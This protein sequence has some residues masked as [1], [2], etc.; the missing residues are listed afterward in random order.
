LPFVSPRTAAASMPAEDPPAITAVP[1]RFRLHRWLPLVAVVAVA[2]VVAATGWHR[3][4]SL[5]NL[6]RYRTA[7]DGF[8]ATH[9][10][11]AILT[12][13][14]VYVIVAALS[15]PGGALVLTISGG[16]LFGTLVG[17]LASL[18]GATIGGTIIFLV[19]RTAFGE[20]LF[21]RAGP[22]AA[23]LAEGF[24]ENAFNYLLF[25][26][27]VP[28]PFFL[29]NLVAALMGMRLGPFLAATVIGIMPAGF[30]LTF[31][32]A[33]IDSAVMAQEATYRA[34]LAAGRADCV[35]DFDAKAAVTPEL[36]GALVALGFA[37]LIP[38]AVKRL[39]TR[40][41]ARS[42]D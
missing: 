12:F 38:V 10:I 13:V 5:E 22:L 1:Q 9:G 37:A 36:I 42:S 21:R 19:A 18:T 28:F 7:L 39:R 25:L 24:R 27:L 40:R 33:G 14:G 23:R 30:A 6:V 32:G 4:L 17:G 20:H 41:A 15:I 31:L 2:V 34:C 35:L 8:V 16:I 11:G 26:R 29:I 3:E